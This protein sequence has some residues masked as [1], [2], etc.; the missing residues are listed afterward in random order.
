MF[1]EHLAKETR[2]HEVEYIRGYYAAMAGL[3]YAYMVLEDPVA[4]FDEPDDPPLN[5]GGPPYTVT[6][7]ELGETID[8]DDFFTRTGISANHLTIIITEWPGPANEAATDPE[9]D[10]HEYHVSATY[11]RF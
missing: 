8:V 6:G 9:W 7:T 1:V 3:R 10:S 5:D 2:L 4:I 11:D